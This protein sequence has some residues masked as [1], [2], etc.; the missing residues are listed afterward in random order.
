[1]LMLGGKIPVLT[2]VALE[3][4]DHFANTTNLGTQYA[5]TY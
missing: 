4:Q 3:N 1:M 5:S 2:L